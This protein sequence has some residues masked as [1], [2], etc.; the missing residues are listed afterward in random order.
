MALRAE[1][2]QGVRRVAMAL[3]LAGSLVPPVGISA[4][5]AGEETAPGSPPAANPAGA[6]P[7]VAPTIPESSTPAPPLSEPPPPNPADAPQNPAPEAAASAAP[8]TAVTSPQPAVAVTL[9]RAT[10]SAAKSVSIVD[11]AFNPG[12]I[13][14]NAGDTV[15]WTNNGKVPE[16]HDVTGDGLDSGQ[17]KS[18]DTYSHTF[19]AAGTF[20]YIC[21][22]HPSMKGTVKVLAAFSGG[23]GASAGSGGSNGGGSDGSA[24]A[25]D[26]SATGSESAAVSS[27][28]AAGSDSSLPAT[29]SDS[30]ELSAVGLVLLSLGLALRLVAPATGRRA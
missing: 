22:I 25:G 8:A 6:A 19:N 1:R 12:S 28:D 2:S 24:T 18:G 15:Q 21:S 13:T 30:L 20:S 7:T 11:F 14:V 9:A 17:L 4:Q 5:A 26:T 23:G 29:G 16:G 10:T 27:P 3:A